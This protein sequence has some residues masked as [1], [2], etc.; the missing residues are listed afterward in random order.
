MAAEDVDPVANLQSSTPLPPPTH[1]QHSS[2]E[3]VK[4]STGLGRVSLPRLSLGV[5]RCRC[6]SHKP[7]GA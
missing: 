7:H 6:V 4:I 1:N 2:A 3:T 5:V